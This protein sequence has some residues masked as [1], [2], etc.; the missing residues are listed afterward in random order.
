MVGYIDKYKDRKVDKQYRHKISQYRQI[1]IYIWIDPI[2]VPG[3]R[4]FLGYR[5]HSVAMTS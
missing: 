3:T 2:I 1:Y 5:R 4:K